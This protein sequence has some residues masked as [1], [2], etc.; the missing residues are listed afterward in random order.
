MSHADKFDQRARRL[1]ADAVAQLSPQ[2]LARI[3]A[4]RHAAV[5]TAP[6]PARRGFGWPWLAASGCA[7][8]F[9]IALGLRFQ[10]SVPEP[11]PPPP[12]AAA[13]VA[14][15][16]PF[17]DDPGLVATLGEDPDLYLWLASMEAQPV[18][19]E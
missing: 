12:Q 8:L 9:A 15:P 2:T 11:A 7:A 17:F 16:S 10:L 19:M 3:R 18:A 5:G 14:V 6:A 13:P 4:A 1:H